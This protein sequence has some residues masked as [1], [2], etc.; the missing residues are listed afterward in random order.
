MFQKDVDPAQ[1]PWE[2]HVVAH[3]EA[4]EYGIDHFEINEIIRIIEKHSLLNGAV[5]EMGAGTGQLTRRLL[6]AG[7][8]FTLDTFDASVA[9][10]RL[11]GELHKGYK[12]G[13][14]RFHGPFCASFYRL[15]FRDAVYALNVS[16]FVLNC[17]RRLEDALR[18]ASRTLRPDG[19]L[20]YSS[21]AA[22][23]DSPDVSDPPVIT[24]QLLL[25][26][27]NTEMWKTV[28]TYHFGKRQLELIWRES[29]F[30]VVEMTEFR[31]RDIPYYRPCLNKTNRLKAS[32]VFTYVVLL[33]KT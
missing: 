33:R 8:S 21:T 14:V 16:N 20:L 10:I 4:A 6:T 3:Y 5:L 24:G 31:V 22:Y 28:E 7:S 17:A 11:L 26:T 2:R 1:A 25:R 30:G 29:G 27:D 13:R 32:D 23:P 9:E 15:P 19:H 12:E 18:E